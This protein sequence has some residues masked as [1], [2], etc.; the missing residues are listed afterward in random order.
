MC[1][2]CNGTVSKIENVRA[3]VD[4]YEHFCGGD[5][6]IFKVHYP[7]AYAKYINYCMEDELFEGDTS[8]W[9][10]WLLNYTF[11][12]VTKEASK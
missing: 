3:A 4:F 2:C 11:Q 8:I 5:Q 7:E 12:D 10:P 6:D 1:A 9:N